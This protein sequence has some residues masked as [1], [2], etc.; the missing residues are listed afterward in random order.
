MSHDPQPEG[1]LVRAMAVI[2]FVAGQ[3]RPV[4]VAE[5]AAG[6]GMPLPTAH[7]MVASLEAARLLARGVGSKRIEVGPRMLE[8]AAR[9]IGAAFRNAGRHAI[10]QD[11][12]RRLGEQCELGIVRDDHVVYVDNIRPITVAGLQFDPG[13]AAPLHCSSTGKL[14]MSRKSERPRER[15]V[16]SLPLTRFTGNTIVDPE[17]LLEE[18]RVVRRRGWASSNEEFVLGVV[19]CAVPVVAPDGTLIAGLGVS[20]PVA[21]VSFVDLER[22]V[23]PMRETAARLSE[24]MIAPDEEARDETGTSP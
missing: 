10:I 1:P 23:P 18:L 11:L 2:D 8:M 15:L 12:A 13:V 24:A 3:R 6:C 22:F 9:V 14:F 16:R 21:R 4:T 17:R 7:R 5:V 19:G 20:V